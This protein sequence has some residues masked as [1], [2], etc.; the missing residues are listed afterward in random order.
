MSRRHILGLLFALLPTALCEGA[1]NRALIIGVEG[2]E[3]ASPLKYVGNDVRKLAESL[4]DRCGFD[5]RE[6]IDTA[7]DERVERIGPA[8]HRDVL[9]RAIEKWMNGISNADSVVIFFSGHGFLDEDGKLYLA[10]LN[11][12]PKNPVPGGIPVAW[13]REQLANCPAKSKVLLLDACHAGSSKD[14]RNTRD[15]AK[16]IEVEMRQLKDVVTFASCEADQ[17]SILWPPKKQSLFTYWLGEAAKGHADGDGN[18]KVEM[19]EL[20][21]YVG[22][23]VSRTARSQDHE[24]QPVLIGGDGVDKPL[25]LSPK[26]VS[27]ILV[28]KDMA[29]KIDAQIRRKNLTGIGVPEFVTGEQGGTLSSEFGTLPA[30]I[31]NALTD[32]LAMLSDGDYVVIN[33]DSLH[34]ELAR[35]GIDPASLL[36]SEAANLRVQGVDVPVLAVGRIRGRENA[37]FR[38]GCRLQKPGAPGQIASANGVCFLNDAEWAMQSHSAQSPTIGPGA[39]APIRLAALDQEAERPHP[40]VSPNCPFKL[41]IWV[42]DQSGKFQQR[43]TYVKDNDCFVTLRKGEV[44]RIEILN[45]S[46]VKEGVFMRLLV[47]GLNTLPERRATRQ[48]GVTVV[49]VSGE[50]ERV[51]AQRANLATANAWH[52]K[53]PIVTADRSVSEPKR[54][55]VNGFY[56]K[57]G[58]GGSFREFEV[59]DAPDSEAGRQGY[60]EQIGLITAAFFAPTSPKA[61]GTKL[62]KEYSR[63]VHK[64]QG[65]KVPGDLLAVINIKYVEQ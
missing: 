19:E 16:A 21:E 48:K 42:R 61:L 28:L 25:V 24:Q 52:L 34:S 31:A 9:M 26:P 57:T 38:L 47:D 63:N 5:V 49:P 50:G 62:G 35:Q 8:T 12:D 51:G 36:S 20:V 65:G 43:P 2:Y 3:K 59:T 23:N 45:S 32:E 29:E 58:A 27:L 33:P 17:E 1:T 64:Y 22:R 39:D 44:Y 4:S 14:V 54:Y 56:T 40:S 7:I 6:I 13:L 30:Y 41:E 46:P 53:A 15:I 37:T 10:S 55:M 60:D 11:C 18:G